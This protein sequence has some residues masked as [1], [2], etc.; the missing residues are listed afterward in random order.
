MGALSQNYSVYAS[1]AQRVDVDSLCG[2]NII[3][4]T[5]YP[6]IHNCFLV[7]SVRGVGTRLAQ[8][9]QVCVWLSFNLQTRLEFYCYFKTKTND[10]KKSAR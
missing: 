5:Q 7:G 1:N 8:A 10:T 2:C 9:K 3:H 6:T 4:Y